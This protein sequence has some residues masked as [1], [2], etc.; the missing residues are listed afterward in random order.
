MN[1][2]QIVTQHL[3]RHKC[4]GL[5]SANK[6]CVCTINTIMSPCLAVGGPC[7]CVPAVK[8]R[9]MVNGRRR[10]VLV[11]FEEP[12]PERWGGQEP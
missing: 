10:T 1:V 4:D 11:P 5:V 8:R 7:T 2:K 9:R 12:P 6:V 3:K